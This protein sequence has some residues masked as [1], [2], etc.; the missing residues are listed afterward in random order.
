MTSKEFKEKIENSPTILNRHILLVDDKV[1]S[2]IKD[3]EV[4]DILKE[5]MPV[6]NI[7]ATTKDVYEYES[8][9]S[10]FKPLYI[11]EYN[12]IKEWLEK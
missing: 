12:K 11:N 1:L 5:K 4:L 8:K 9:V 3:L 6:I 2:V 7:I 10:G